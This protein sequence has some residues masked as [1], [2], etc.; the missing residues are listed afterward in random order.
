MADFWKLVNTVI[1]Q[2]DLLLLV[3]D[4][5]M[6]TQTLNKEVVD[7]VHKA[8][9]PLIYVLTKSDLAGK[10]ESERAKKFFRPCVFVSARQYQGTTMLR[11]RILIEGKKHYKGKESFTVGV[12]GYPN[13]GK[14]TLINAM[15]GK[16]SAPTSPQSGHTRGVQKIKAGNLIMLLDTPGV[17]PYHEKDDAKHQLIGTID[18][19]K[20][21]EPD[22][23]VMELMDLYPGKIEAFYGVDV[24]KDKDA[25]LET[26]ALKR[27][28]LEKGGG[29]DT[30]RMARQIL[31]DWQEG[32]IR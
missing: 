7:K 9:K 27:R 30:P 17:I 19:T 12:L 21:K 31:R 18:F 11:E 2:S 29:A 6:P 13:V 32:V 24:D 1:E 26:I 3:L 22:L 23:A 28:M 10:E 4:A 15:K 14:S 5:R 25:V 20:A 8:G 16:H